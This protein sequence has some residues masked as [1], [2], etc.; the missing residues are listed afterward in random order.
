MKNKVGKIK[1]LKGLEKYTI[2]IILLIGMISV[3]AVILLMN[4][5]HSLY[6]MPKVEKGVV[7]LNE[8]SYQDDGIIKLNGQWEFYYDQLL[9][10]HDFYTKEPLKP[11]GYI[12]MPR[13]WDGYKIDGKEIN[14]MGYGTYK[15]RV[16]NS[17]VENLA[18]RLPYRFTDYT[19]M[20]DDEIIATKEP[21][22]RI[23]LETKNVFFKPSSRNFDI[24]IQVPSQAFFDGGTHLPIYIGSQE[25]LINKE[26]KDL[27]KD[28]LFF[29]SLIIM[30]LYHVALYAFLRRMKYI[31]Y[32]GLLCIAV[33]LRSIHVHEAL[34][35]NNFMPLSFQTF[36]Y[37]NVA[38]LLLI[39]ILFG[40]F[41]SGLYPLESSKKV[42]KAFQG[43]SILMIIITLVF[44]YPVYG[45]FRGLNNIVLI[46][47][48]VYYLSVMLKAAFRNREGANIMVFAMAFM[49]VSV[50]NDVLYVSNMKIFSYLYGMT[51]YSIVIF[52]F[53]LAI[54]LSK[55]YADTFIS[56]DNL[57]KKLM[58]LDKI[59]DEFLANTSHE[60]RTPL[61][62]IIG[63][64][65]SL[66]EG[67]A[68]EITDEVHKNLSIVAA[69]SKRL[70]NLVNS[71]L[72]YSKLKH[73]DINLD[74]RPINLHQLVDLILTVFKMT[75]D[76]NNISLKNKVPKGLPYVLADD[77][78]LQQILYNLI[79]NAIKFTDEG[80]VS[81]SARLHH[82][83]IEV[84]IE[85]TGIGIEESKIEDIFH[86]YEQIDTSISKQQI[87]TG[88]GLSITKN[89]VEIQG[90]SIRCHST[91]RK[92]S[93]FIFTLPISSHKHSPTTEEGFKVIEKQLD[94]QQASASLDNLQL[95]NN[96]PTILVVDDEQINIQVLVNQLS[97][98]NYYVV[99][100]T[101]G[102]DALELVD[103]IDFDLVILDAMMPKMSGYE[104]AK[105]IRERFSLIE[106]PILILTAN[107]QLSN[108]CL[109]FDCGTNDY[110]TKPFEKQELLARIDTL[111]TMKNAVEQ[112]I[113]DPLTDIYNRKHLFALAEL[114]FEDHRRD[115]KSMAVI[116]IDI[117][118]FKLINDTYGHVEGD[119]ILIE[120]VSRCKK[121]IRDTDLFGRYGGEEFLIVLPNIAMDEAIA[122]AERIKQS[123]SSKPVISDEGLE[124]EVTISTGIAINKPIYQNL[125][126]MYKDVDRALYKAKLNGKNR[127]EVAM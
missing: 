10:Y 27:I 85:D 48:A 16:I 97:L 60:L 58:S 93:S 46:A 5:S 96:K 83:L 33:A 62:G 115:S 24:I 74:L 34:L 118:N 22:D 29:A 30:G 122:L 82:N 50:L 88:I 43:Y 17:S 32:F 65:E 47:C 73:K 38:S 91:V 42:L 92:G 117:D 21:A 66:I 106:L 113:K 55:I 20:I 41:I 31:L 87:G 89:L 80:E 49:L 120:I 40:S 98:H 111:I 53:A 61:N 15:L 45:Y 72:D 37:F 79:G 121:V 103:E 86:S 99:T 64:T 1:I 68:G 101:N 81:V 7:D 23:V 35:I 70:S 56:V 18:I 94:Y 110:V 14:K 84:S 112:S 124:I 125:H 54:I 75:K 4:S 109:A 107:N 126:E 100:A 28:M 39:I 44:P 119:N 116:M 90:G 3:V 123:I 69:S 104:V 52:I 36:Y 63:I 25:A 76:N 127:V 11:S 102:E 12:D 105:K 51:T 114:I 6:K 108:I 19:I 77:G 95:N 78:R 67:A 26:K 2:Y 59:K 71:I 9:A 8:W 57:S 13:S